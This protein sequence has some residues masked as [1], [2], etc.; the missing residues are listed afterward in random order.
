M[1]KAEEKTCSVLG[2]G[3]HNIIP[4]NLLWSSEECHLLFKSGKWG[5][6]CFTLNGAR[7]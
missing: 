3:F 4:L 6:G 7:H 2:S 5:Y 1:F